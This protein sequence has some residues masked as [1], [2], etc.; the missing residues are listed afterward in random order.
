MEGGR[1]LDAVK[2]VE[3]RLMNKGFLEEIGMPMVVLL[4]R[5]K[6]RFSNITITATNFQGEFKFYHLCCLLTPHP[7]YVQ[8]HP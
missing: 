5:K 3:P 7:R 6:N 1:V 2:D 4:N 8:K